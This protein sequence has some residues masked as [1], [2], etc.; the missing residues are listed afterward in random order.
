MERGRNVD[1]FSFSLIGLREWSGDTQVAAGESGC[2][3]LAFLVL[4]P[5]PPSWPSKARLL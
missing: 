2:D 5:L 1:E 4:L 3:L